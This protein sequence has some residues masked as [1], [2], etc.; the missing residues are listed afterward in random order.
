MAPYEK[1]HYLEHPE[2]TDQAGNNEQNGDGE[3]T[4]KGNSLLTP[5]RA[6]NV[7]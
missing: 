4:H 5:P 7:V 3:D 6:Q 1:R 2:G